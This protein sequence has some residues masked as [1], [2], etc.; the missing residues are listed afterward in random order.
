MPI[1]I[2]D[3]LDLG[4]LLGTGSCGEVRR[5]RYK[6]GTK[7][8]AVKCVGAQ[9]LQRSEEKRARIRTEIA[10]MRLVE[11]PNLLHLHEAVVSSCGDVFIITELVNGSELFDEL[12]RSGPFAPDRALHCF[13]QIVSALDYLHSLLIAHRDL[14]LENVLLEHGV[15]VKLIDFG[16]SRMSPIGF[17]LM[18]TRCGSPHY[19]APEVLSAEAGYDGCRADLWSLGVVLYALL[20][21]TLPFS[22]STLPQVLKNI[23]QVKFDMP[24]SVPKPLSS[25]IHSLLSLDPLARPSAAELRK[26]PALGA[27]AEMSPSWPLTSVLDLDNECLD[28]IESVDDDILEDLCALD[29]GEVALLREELSGGTAPYF[30]LLLYEI[31]RHRRAASRAL[32]RSHRISAEE[33]SKK[34]NRLIEKY[35][36]ELS[37]PHS[38]FSSPDSSRHNR[39]SPSPIPSSE[40]KIM[41]PLVPKRRSWL[42]CQLYRI[43]SC[44]HYSRMPD[45]G[46]EDSHFLSCVD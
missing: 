34:A 16:M 4:A 46:D 33:H 1:S 6:G 9:L 18:H 20:T 38:Q 45:A 7:E 41:D 19:A 21:G 24:N 31:F 2:L 42:W 43:F 30:L 36:N 26:H 35:C 5:C 23:M 27:F 29:L 28:R 12:E 10:I 22:G 17:G 44:L 3:G 39:R 14:K 11:H 40:R 8:L 25:L 32:K 13:A 15:K 37:M